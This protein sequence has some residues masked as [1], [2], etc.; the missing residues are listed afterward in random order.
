[1]GM[2]LFHV[3]DGWIRIEFWMERL[4]FSCLDELGYVTGRIVQVTKCPG[5]HRTDIHTCWRGIPIH[6][7]LKSPLSAF[8]NSFHTEV[9]FCHGPFLEGVYLSSQNFKL[10]EVLAGEVFCLIVF[11]RAPLLV[12][13]GYETVPATNALVMINNDDA[14]FSLKGGTRGADL[15]TCS[16][17][18]VVAKDRNH[19]FD[20]RGIFALFTN[21]HPI[22]KHPWW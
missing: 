1:M 11:I 19:E 12:G 17:L 4:S 16:L 5:T 20:N 3:I 8:F 2:G 6:A 15:Y 10:R 7:G 21:K 18:T 22:P 14:V 13:T 9:A